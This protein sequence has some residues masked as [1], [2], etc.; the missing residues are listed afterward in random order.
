MHTVRVTDDKTLRE[1]Q[2]AARR[3][4]AA[5]ATIAAGNKEKDAAKATISDWL[6]EHRKIELEQLKIGAGV[7]LEGVM[8]IVVDKQ[9]KLDQNALRTEEPVLFARFEKD[10]PTVKWASQC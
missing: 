2:E 8:L 5:N 3:L 9:R 1:L 4:K 10:V 7:N 6:K